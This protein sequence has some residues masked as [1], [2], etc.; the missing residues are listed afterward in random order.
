MSIRKHYIIIGNRRHGYTLVPARKA[1]TLICRSANIEA[2][3]P[4]D[5]IPRILSELP[6]LIVQQRSLST[7]APQTE[8]VRFRVSED[9]RAQIEHNA[10]EAGY[11]NI[12][13]YLRDV[14]L[15]RI[16]TEKK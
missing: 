1:T 4:N 11:E 12:S 6:R 5:E 9:E 14:A 7:D 2:R 15:H 13:A 3:Y 8:V 10:F 16:D